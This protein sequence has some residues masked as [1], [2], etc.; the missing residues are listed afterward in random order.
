MESTYSG[1]AESV[2]KVC[3]ILQVQRLV[4]TRMSDAQSDE[5]TQTRGSEQ[6]ESRHQNKQS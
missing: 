1:I 6:T 3:G 4:V 5:D 2:V